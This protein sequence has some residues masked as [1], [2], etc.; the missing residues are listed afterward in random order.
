[1]K[2]FKVVIHFEG[3]FDYEITADTREEAEE[4]AQSYVDELP[5]NSEIFAENLADCFVD[6]SW[7]IT[8]EE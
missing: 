1:M 5:S 2:K 4:I 7:E 3:A 8:Y 6:D